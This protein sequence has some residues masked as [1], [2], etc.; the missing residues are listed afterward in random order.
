MLVKWGRCFGIEQGNIVIVRNS[1][2]IEGSSV[3]I[4]VTVKHGTIGT[5]LW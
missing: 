4:V 3:G 2:G 5:S 1:I